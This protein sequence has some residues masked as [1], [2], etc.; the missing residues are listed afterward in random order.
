MTHATFVWNE[1]YTR[2]VEK[3][4][5]FYAAT[6]G[7]TYEGM[8]MPHQ[9]RIYWVARQAGKPI[10]GLMDMRGIVPDGEPPHW[11]GYIEVDDIDRCVATIEA[12]GGQDRPADL[13]RS[14]RRPHRHRRRFH[15]CVLGLDNLDTPTLSGRS[16]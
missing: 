13:R 16:R 14:E 5:A 7:W 1:L 2:D 12:S 3:A 10:A 15:R 4:K 6:I 8:P 9:D 11:L